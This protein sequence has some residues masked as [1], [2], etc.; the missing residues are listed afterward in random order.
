[1]SS[2]QISL[3]VDQARNANLGSPPA[4]IDATEFVRSVYELAHV[5]WALSLSKERMLTELAG[6]LA[7]NTYRRA[8]LG[9]E[10]QFGTD[11]DRQKRNRAISARAEE[12]HRNN[13]RLSE[14]A[15]AQKLS[16]E[17]KLSPK[18]IKRV[19]KLGR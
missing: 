16:T 2:D 15:I 7:A 3:F 6:S 12:L 10:A 8:R 11:A 5:Q 1:M 18:Q 9:H 13:P 17:T 4:T 19:L 14:H